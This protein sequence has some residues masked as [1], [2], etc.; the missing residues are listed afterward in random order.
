MKQ[1]QAD[2]EPPSEHSRKK[3]TQKSLLDGLEYYG[4]NMDIIDIPDQKWDLVEK[5]FKWF[6]DSGD[7]EN[8]NGWLTRY[9][10]RVSEIFRIPVIES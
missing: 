10:E 9:L 3:I 2:S 7:S 8:V 5:Y 4:F 6:G 1:L